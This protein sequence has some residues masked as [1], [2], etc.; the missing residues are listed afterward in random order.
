MD[1]KKQETKTC[2]GCLKALDVSKFYR[3][4][5]KW[6][7]RCKRCYNKQS[8]KNKKINKN[9]QTS[10]VKGTGKWQINKFSLLDKEI[11]DS[12]NR[13]LLSDLTLKEIAVKHRIKI[14]TFYGWHNRGYMATQRVNGRRRS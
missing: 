5:L 9:K 12:M 4:G 6:Q 3:A 2:K 8:Y 1:N 11:R 10:K 13:D 7:S 14:T